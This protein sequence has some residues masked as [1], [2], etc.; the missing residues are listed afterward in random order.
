[1]TAP[2]RLA[3][4]VGGP[5]SKRLV[6][7]LAMQ[8]G[9]QRST[10]SLQFGCTGTAGVSSVVC[11]SAGVSSI[12]A[13]GMSS[14]EVGRAGT[15]SISVAGMSNREVERAGTSSIGSAGLFSMVESLKDGASSRVRG[16]EYLDTDVYEFKGSKEKNTFCIVCSVKIKIIKLLNL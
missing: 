8:P 13:A 9:V 14:T 10:L 11:N 1:M 16:A 6:G 2:I 5:G 15:S 4:V 12:L 7:L 3:G